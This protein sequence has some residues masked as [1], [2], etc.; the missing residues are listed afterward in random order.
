MTS[1]ALQP[2]YTLLFWCAK[3]IEHI[4]L[5][6][7][8]TPC[9]HQSGFSRYNSVLG[10][11][12]AWVFSST[13]IQRRIKVSITSWDL[14]FW[15]ASNNVIAP[16][17]YTTIIF[18]S[19]FLNILHTLPGLFFRLSRACGNRIYTTYGNTFECMRLY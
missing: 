7:G 10:E 3:V 2:A 14:Y 16:Q 11:K 9:T 6:C 17:L 4:L 8:C 5:F 15:H 18:V 19:I 12:Y 13:T 1:F